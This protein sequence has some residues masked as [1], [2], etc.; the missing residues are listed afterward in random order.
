MGQGA[1]ALLAEASERHTEE[2][3]KRATEWV[4][5]TLE[6]FVE[7][8]EF[9]GK[10][11][12]RLYLS[13]V[14]VTQK[15]IDEGMFR[16]NQEGWYYSQNIETEIVALFYIDIIL[17]DAIP[18]EDKALAIIEFD[19]GTEE[20]EGAGYGYGPYFKGY[21]DAPW[22]VLSRA[23]I[24]ERREYFRVRNEGI[25]ELQNIIM[26]PLASDEAKKKARKEL[27]IP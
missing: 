26:N 1:A 2:E 12:G 9:K 15:E 14:L 13:R 10:M 11:R 3:I 24:D 25:A 17:D 20:K 18:E 16:Q 4:E 7:F 27:G 8:E 19:V 5:R 6:R 21:P 23:E 22:Y